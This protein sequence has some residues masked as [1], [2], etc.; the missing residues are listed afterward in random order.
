[1]ATYSLRDRVKVLTI[2]PGTGALTVLG[3]V[4]KFQTLAQAGLT[5]VGVTFAYVIELPSGPWETG[6]C[7]VQS[8]GTLARSFEDSSTKAVLSLTGEAGTT[9]SLTLSAN[10]LPQIVKANAIV[11]VT[12]IAASSATQVLQAPAFGHIA[13]DITLASNCV[14]T[15]AG[16]TVGQLQVVSTFVR[17]NATAGW[18]LTLPTPV[19]WAGGSP[20]VP[21]TVAG[22]IDVFHFRTPDGGVTWLGD[23]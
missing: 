18:V 12:T 10:S 8:D 22:K 4:P 7:V 23:F 15:L 19:S 1:M 5:A 11:P 2:T 3:P 21:N 20:P 6:T 13:F 9:I 14:F 16:G 17:Q